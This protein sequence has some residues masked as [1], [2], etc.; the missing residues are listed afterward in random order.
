MKQKMLY[1][2]P[3]DV[4]TDILESMKLVQSGYLSGA[5][6][7]ST[8]I[9]MGDYIILLL[10]C[11]EITRSTGAGAGAQIYMLSKIFSDNTAYGTS[12]IY[13]SSNV[14]VTIT[15]GT[16]DTITLTPSSSS[17]DVYYA[18]YAVM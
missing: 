8:T 16:D 6:S 3:S 7:D 12:N 17:Y 1:G 4:A 2:K 18:L 13:E 11:R 14:R 5:D 9:N 15:K 10:F